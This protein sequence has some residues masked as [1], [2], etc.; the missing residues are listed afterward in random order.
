MEVAGLGIMSE[1]EA[2][3]SAVPV[4]PTAVLRMRPGFDLSIRYHRTGLTS[5]SV[6]EACMV[7]AQGSLRCGKL[8][9]KE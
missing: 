9:K 3:S 7:E 6:R 2:R 8:V 5:A 1:F 4:A